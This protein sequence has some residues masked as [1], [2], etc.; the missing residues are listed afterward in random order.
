MY[1]FI[2]VGRKKTFPWKIG[3]LC[4]YSLVRL[5]LISI[6]IFCNMALLRERHQKI[7]KIQ[8]FL[9]PIGMRDVLSFQRRQTLLLCD[10]QLIFPKLCTGY[11]LVSVS[12][13]WSFFIEPHR[14]MVVV[15]KVVVLSVWAFKYFNTDFDSLSFYISMILLVAR[16]RC[17]TLCFDSWS[18]YYPFML[19]FSFIVQGLV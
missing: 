1:C 8:G 5:I 16:L 11:C 15:Q 12:G 6:L 7:K 2:I 9:L 19:T 4:S 3:T 14:E 17:V 18:H 13:Y 10:M